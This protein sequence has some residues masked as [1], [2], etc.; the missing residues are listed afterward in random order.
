MFFLNLHSDRI[1]EDLCL[2]ED[3]QLAVVQNIPH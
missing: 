1:Q 3:R 2:M